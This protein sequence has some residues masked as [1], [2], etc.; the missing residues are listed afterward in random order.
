MY[1]KMF[2]TNLRDKLNKISVYYS[3]PVRLN[4][5]TTLSSIDLG[6]IENAIK[7]DIGRYIIIHNST[8]T[9]LWRLKR[10]EFLFAFN[11]RIDI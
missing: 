10:Y 5:F 9:N 1:V 4:M 8:D 6:Q 7:F 3:S 11:N 2:S